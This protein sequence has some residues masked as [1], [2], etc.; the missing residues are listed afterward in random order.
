MTLR[1][2]ASAAWLLVFTR[3]TFPRSF[4][5]NVLILQSSLT[6]DCDHLS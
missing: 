3:D 1:R 4:A 2:R 5:A 6:I